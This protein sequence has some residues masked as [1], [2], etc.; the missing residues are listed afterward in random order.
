MVRLI[1]ESPAPNI[2][3]SDG[4]AEISI[5][6]KPA[7]LLEDEAYNLSGFAYRK[8]GKYNQALR[9]YDTALKL[10]PHNLG[11]LESLGAIAG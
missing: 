11:A 6:D 8:L 9:F 1:E 4:S 10:N 5:G 3:L 2:E 7:M